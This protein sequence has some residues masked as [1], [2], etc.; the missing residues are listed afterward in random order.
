MRTS[1]RCREGV[2]VIPEPAIH[3]HRPRHYRTVCGY[4]LRTP[5]GACRRAGH[6]SRVLAEI[7]APML[8]KSAENRL[9]RPDPLARSPLMTSLK[10]FARGATYCTRMLSCGLR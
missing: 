6:R 1:I 10:V 4:G 9:V 5:C 7:G 3:N 8:H 2:D